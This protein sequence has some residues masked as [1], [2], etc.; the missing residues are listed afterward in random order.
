[1]PSPDASN[2]PRAPWLSLEKGKEEREE[3][4]Q[5]EGEDSGSDDEG[6]DELR[7]YEDQSARAGVE[8]QPPGTMSII[9]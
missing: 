3:E 9:A 6:L 2:L 5:I 7:E 8:A 4:V 1:M